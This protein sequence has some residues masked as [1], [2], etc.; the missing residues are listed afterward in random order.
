MGSSLV[1]P[2]AVN[3]FTHESVDSAS[4][5]IP[6]YDIN[7][8]GVE[9]K[10]VNSIINFNQ[11]SDQSMIHNTN[12]DIFRKWSGQSDFQFGFI[13]LGEQKMPKTLACNNVN[14]KSLIEGHH[15]VRKTGKPNF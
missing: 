8:A 10:F 6:I 3:A 14:N 11:F 7:H 13:P 9:E 1:V 4:I 5:F 2:G 12:S 15:I